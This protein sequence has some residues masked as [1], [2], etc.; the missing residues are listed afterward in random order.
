MSA[1]PSLAKAWRQP[2]QPHT[3]DEGSG[4]AAPIRRRPGRDARSLLMALGAALMLAGVPARAEVVLVPRSELFA[5]MLGQQVERL[6]D[7]VVSLQVYA[8]Q[9]LAGYL[10]L[11][12]LRSELA[13]CG[14]CN[15][16]QALVRQIGELQAY[17]IDEHR[18]LC[19][20]IDTVKEMVPSNVQAIDIMNKVTGLHAVCERYQRELEINAMK[21]QLRDARQKFE[22]RLKAGDVGAYSEIGI[23]ILETFR[24]SR[25][26]SPADRLD[27][28]CSY[29]TE[30]MQR[31]DIGSLVALSEYCYPD[32]DTYRDMTRRLV[33]CTQTLP[34]ADRC[35]HSLTRVVAAYSTSR[36]PGRPYAVEPDEKEGHRIWQALVA[37]WEKRAAG[38]PQD[39]GVRKAL[40]TAREMVDLQEA[41]LQPFPPAGS[42]GRAAIRTELSNWCE[43]IRERATRAEML[44]YHCDCFVNETDRHLEAGRLNWAKVKAEGRFDFT[45]VSACVDRPAMADA[46]VARQRSE[47]SATPQTDRYLACAHDAIA[48]DLPLEHLRQR[49]AAGWQGVLEPKCGTASSPTQQA[50]PAPRGVP[51]SAPSRSA[52]IA[53]PAREARS[54]NGAA[55]L[56]SFCAVIVTAHYQPSSIS[57]RRS[58]P[59]MES[60]QRAVSVMSS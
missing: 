32:G 25:A 44:S 14:T 20:G 42:S 38:A 29:L 33:Q 12:R 2:I 27:I 35:A 10:E 13:A 51:G 59:T 56:A 22:Q 30:G 8:G 48:S 28:G 26:M 31:G 16:E 60:P 21:V 24:T 5:Y 17:L 1:S 4:P 40:D 58:V 52:E 54:C 7:N 50:K 41:A 53:R 55:L 3:G 6:V 45:L 19:S 9:S 23:G 15:R 39:G 18:T 46:W 11:E 36:A 43:G 37:Y 34:Q 57:C 47:L 49:Y